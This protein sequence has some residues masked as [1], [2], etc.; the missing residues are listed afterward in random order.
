MQ[1]VSNFSNMVMNFSASEPIECDAVI[2]AGTSI[3]ISSSFED[4]WS[5]EGAVVNHLY[6][7]S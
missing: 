6:S 5:I 7:S 3:N 4:P 1:G 2:L